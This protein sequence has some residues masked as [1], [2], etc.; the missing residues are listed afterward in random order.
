MCFAN[1]CLA[2]FGVYPTQTLGADGKLRFHS[3]NPVTLTDGDKS[4]GKSYYFTLD[5]IAIGNPKVSQFC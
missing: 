4:L 2:K 5:G 3:D 1:R